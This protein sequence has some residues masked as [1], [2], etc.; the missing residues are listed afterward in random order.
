M[1]FC[2]NCGIE[3]SEGI[4]FCPQC[5]MKNTTSPLLE[6]NE[7][8]N[9]NGMQ[10]QA[11]IL[12]NEQ[13]N[14]VIPKNTGIGKYVIAILITAGIVFG[15][16]TYNQ[17]G[18]SIIPSSNPWISVTTEE[19]MIKLM[20][21]LEPLGDYALIDLL[22]PDNERS[23]DEINALNKAKSFDFFGKN[24]RFAYRKD[25]SEYALRLDEGLKLSK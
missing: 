8:D 21:I 9:K 16:I 4:N 1:A 20:V 2:G 23:R 15:I 7:L 14:V 25:M 10:N 13:Q 5:G 22:T 24:I 19:Q 6:K 17:N 12:E 18:G 11:K 3:L